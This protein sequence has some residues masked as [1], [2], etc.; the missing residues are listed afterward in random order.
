VNVAAVVVL[1]AIYCFWLYMMLLVHRDYEGRRRGTLPLTATFYT[2]G[3]AGPFILLGRRRNW[4]AAL[5]GWLKRLTR[6]GARLVEKDGGS[7]VPSA[8]EIEISLIR[9]DGQSVVSAHPQQAGT[10]TGLRV[11]SFVL[12][13]AIRERATDVHFEPEPDKLKVRYR[14]D[15]ILHLRQSYPIEMAPGV[16]SALKVLAGEDMAERRRAQ[17]GSFSALFED[18]SIDF[19]TATTGTSH[20]EKMVVRI[21]DRKVSLRRLDALGLRK[22]TLEQLSAIVDSPTGMLLLCGPTGCGKTTTL[23]AAIQSVDSLEK[24]VI[25]VEDPIEYNLEDVTQLNINEKAGITF[26]RL[27]RNTLRQDPDVLMVGE[28]RD[29]ETAEIAMQ[30]ALT[31]HFVY[32]TVHA[33]DSVSALFRLFNL[34]VKPYL[35]ASSLTAILAQRLLRKL[36]RRCRIARKPTA[37]EIQRYRID[38]AKVRVLYEPRGCRRCYATGYRERT[39]VFELLTL[40]DRLRDLVHGSPSLEQLRN[41]AKKAGMVSLRQDALAKALMGITSLE[42]A[43]RIT[44]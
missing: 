18:R 17:D 33:N 20:G 37:E 41:A 2:L 1:L 28:I 44:R 36:C 27:L 34:G 13:D 19:R 4:V 15:G 12:Q 10:A 26:A 42:E 29:K 39:G 38:P 21:L 14:I 16:V 25:T 22:K 3:F 35:I 6:A 40:D 31:G 43:L 8:D 32:T 24:N 5:P 23:Y 30:A 9:H 7:P 11:A